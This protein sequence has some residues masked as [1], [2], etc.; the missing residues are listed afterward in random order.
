MNQDRRRALSLR[1]SFALP[2]L[3]VITVVRVLDTGTVS[4][5]AGF[6]SFLISMCIDAP[7]STTNY[8]SSVFV[9]DGASNDQT[10]EGE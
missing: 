6:T 1:R 7:E 5:S 10:S 2:P 9:E 3:A 4:S 8:M